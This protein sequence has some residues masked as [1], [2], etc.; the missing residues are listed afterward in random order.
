MGQHWVNAVLPNLLFRPDGTRRRAPWR[1]LFAARDGRMIPPFRRLLFKK[2][3][4]TRAFVAPD[5]SEA[6]K[7]PAMAHWIARHDTPAPADLAR[8]AATAQAWPPVLLRIEADPAGPPDLAALAAALDAVAGLRLRRTLGPPAAAPD[9]LRQRLAARLRAS[10]DP[11]DAQPRPGE[12]LVVVGAGVLPRPHGPRLLVEALASAALAYGDEAALDAD[13]LPVYPW[14]KPR[15]SPELAARGVLI[16]GMAALAPQAARAAIAVAEGPLSARLDRIALGLAPAAIAHVPHLLHY[17]LG[18]R[19]PPLPDVLPPLPEPLPVASVIIPT[20]DGWGL[21]GPCL[22]SLA[23]TDWPADR[24]E[25]IVVDNGSTEPECLAGLAR[26]EAAGAV[27]VLRDARPFNFAQLNNAAAAAARGSLLVFLNNDTLALRPD[28]LAL[29]A[30]YAVQPGIGAVGP[31]LL[32][33]DGTVQHG[34][35]VLG[36]AGRAVHA[37]L[38][39]AADAGGYAGLAG[40]TREVSAVTG[41]CLAVTRAAFEAAGGFDEGFAV[42]FNDVVLCCD[43]MRLGYRNLYLAEPLFQHL[44]SRT[45][46]RP[47]SA[48]KQ[49]EEERAAEAFRRRHPAL[50]EADPNYSPNLS[51]VTPYATLVPPRAPPAWRH[52]QPDRGA[53][54]PGDPSS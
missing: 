48:A 14:F 52:P 45:R 32:Y 18:P 20:R 26:A 24:L 8:M 39:L 50:F 21:L 29:L 16:R 40:I 51:R 46:G 43:L 54:G 42:A 1:W 3:G 11:A 2:S 10:A 15:F 33:G 37:H 38:G 23:A 31:K 27:R 17:S 53:A 4:M 47:V 22:H 19:P 35:I 9:D 30:R 41:A 7:A 5:L 49:A 34:G 44:E 36:I 28:W 6:L 13:G 12:A 25:V